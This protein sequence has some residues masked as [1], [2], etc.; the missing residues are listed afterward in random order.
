MAT[1]YSPQIVTNGLVLYLDAA[2]PRSYVS[3]STNWYSL[4]SVTTSGSLIN[5]P[6]YSS[7]N[8]GSIVFDGVDDYI[9]LNTT[10][11][12]WQS[13]N[14]MTVISTFKLSSWPD[15]FT[16]NRAPLLAKTSGSVSFEFSLWIN[17]NVPSWGGNTYTT[18]FECWTFN[19]SSDVVLVSAPQNAITLNTVYTVA[20]VLDL[21]S[22]PYA[23]I[24]INGNL[25]NT[26]STKSGVMT[27]GSAPIRIA[28]RLPDAYATT[29]QYLNGNIYTTQIYNRALSATEIQ[30]NFNALKG[31]YGI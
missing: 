5:S 12:I 8:L 29:G 10:N 4:P 2:N 20:G 24:Y 13:N 21:N 18:T 7:T 11:S 31:R 3:G 1:E 22:S 26:T 30:Q 9:E 15:S 16:Q 27:A 17:G 19:G 14:A 6:T 25:S 28:A 23:S